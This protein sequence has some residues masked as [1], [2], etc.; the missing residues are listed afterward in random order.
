VPFPAFLANEL[1]ALMVD[2]DRDDLVFTAADGGVLRVSSWRRG[3]FSPAV[4][5]LTRQV[6]GFPTVTPHDLRHT[7]VSLA[8]SAGANVKAVQTMLG[9]AFA[10]LT[11]D[12]YADLFP[13]DLEQVSA[14]LDQARLVA[15]RSTADQLRTETEQGS[16]RNAQSQPSTSENTSRGGGIRTHGLFVPNEA[17]YQA[18]PHPA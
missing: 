2:K 1:A 11:L 16:D 5:R 13:D 6:R 18:A 15:L 8:I 3:V 12:T 9:H 4:R 7:A 10:V 17:R 14:A